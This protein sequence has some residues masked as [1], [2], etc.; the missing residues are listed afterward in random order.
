MWQKNKRF[1]WFLYISYWI[2]ATQN[3]I[4]NGTKLT[5]QTHRSTYRVSDKPSSLL[6]YE[7]EITFL[8]QEAKKD[9]EQSIPNATAELKPYDV[10][11]LYLPPYI[12]FY[13][14]TRYK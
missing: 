4:R 9:D 5:L 2:T 6:I 1:I 13:T 14:H 8:V 11:Y 7:C 10:I 12:H 3:Y